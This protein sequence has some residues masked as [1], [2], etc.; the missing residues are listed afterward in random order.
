MKKLEKYLHFSFNLQLTSHLSFKCFSC[1]QPSITYVL[2]AV[3]ALTGVANHYLTPHLRK[4]LPWLI[5][6]SPVLKSAEYDLFE[7]RGGAAFLILSCLPF[8]LRFCVE[9]LLL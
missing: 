4:E 7:A 3:T 1:F 2:F 9:K 8:F 5:G 6:S